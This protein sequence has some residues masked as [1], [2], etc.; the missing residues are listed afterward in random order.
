MPHSLVIQTSFLGDVV[1]T[2][3]LLDVLATRGTVD[4]VTTPGAAPLLANHPAIRRVVPWDKRGRERGLAGLW[5][6]ARDV[7]APDTE[8][9]AYCVQGSWR[10]AALAVAAGYRT[11]VGFDT[12]D[13]RLLYTRRVLYRAG[14]HHTV[15]LLDLAGG[16]AETEAPARPRVFPGEAERAAVDALLDDWHDADDLVALAP[17]SIWG[18]K[19]WPHFPALAALLAPQHRLV[20]VGSRDDQPLAAAIESAAPGRTRDATGRLSLLGSAELLRRCVLLVTND[21][22]PQHLASAV[23]T[24][25][26]TIFGPTVPAFGFGPLAPHSV[27][28]EHP[29]LPCRP[30]HRHGPPACPLGHWRCMRDLDAAAVMARARPI[31][32]TSARP[33]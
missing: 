13:G 28:A 30:C 12:S 29:D 7:R 1:L 14:E 31:L 32:Q 25:T 20:V 24:P 17:G 22:A 3:P 18:T 15:R 6:L 19:R 21:S 26:V 9:V 5:R 11:R 27:V 10:T 8:A 33:S 4:V 23:G 2:T 16:A